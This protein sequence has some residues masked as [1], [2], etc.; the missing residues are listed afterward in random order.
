MPTYDTFMQM[1]TECYDRMGVF[2]NFESLSR[3]LEELGLTIG[4][5]ERDLY[6]FLLDGN[7]YP[8]GLL[9]PHNGPNGVVLGIYVEEDNG[10]TQ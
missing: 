5:H 9:I 10:N 2:D 6:T 3:F 7:N 1:V 4:P 8:I